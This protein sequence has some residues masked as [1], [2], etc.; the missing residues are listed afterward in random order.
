M[1]NGWTTVLNRKLSEIFVL[2]VALVFFLDAVNIDD[3]CSFG[4]IHEEYEG[5]STEDYHSF[6]IEKIVAPGLPITHTTTYQQ[7]NKGKS[8]IFLIDEDSPSLPPP[9]T[10]TQEMMMHCKGNLSEKLTW[11]HIHTFN[12]HSFCKLQI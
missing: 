3:I 4:M 8:S 10:I 12:F 2:I 11:R 7:S 9:L 1:N 5:Q 6:D